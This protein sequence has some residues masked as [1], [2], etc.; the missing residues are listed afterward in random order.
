MSALPLETDIFHAQETS[1]VGQKLTFT[2]EGR[3]VPS[4]SSL[5]TR[6]FEISS[7]FDGRSGVWP[8]AP[9]FSVA[10]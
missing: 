10:M 4:S 7:D 8:A 5:V 2:A 9:V 1:A 3:S 6:T